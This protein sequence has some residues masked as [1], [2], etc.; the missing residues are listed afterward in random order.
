MPSVE[1]LNELL[2]LGSSIY[3]AC[4]EPNVARVEVIAELRRY[5]ALA[6][7]KPRYLKKPSLLKSGWAVTFS[8]MFVA[9]QADHLVKRQSLLA[10][11]VA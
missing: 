6:V 1:Y 9:D 4:N 10:K 11:Q 8:I 7:E 2:E 3:P 5:T